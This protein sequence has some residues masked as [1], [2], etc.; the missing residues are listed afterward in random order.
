MRLAEAPQDELVGL[1]VVLD[2]QGRV[3]GGEAAQTLPQL[4]LV[5]LGTRHH[6]NGQQRVGHLPR[7]HDERGDLVR[8]RVAG[9]GPA[10]LRDRADIAG[11]ALRHRALGAAERR[12]HRT[13]TLV[14]VVVVVPH[15]RTVERGYMPGHVHGGVRAQRPGEHPDEAD[16]PDVRVGGRLDHLG[17]EG[18]GGVTRDGGSAGADDREDLRGRVLDR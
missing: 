1:G 16:A 9:L 17:D 6:G 11:D 3:L 15:T 10:Q 14:L 5:G 13:H 12:R 2:A 8:Q 4:V 7:A 18:S